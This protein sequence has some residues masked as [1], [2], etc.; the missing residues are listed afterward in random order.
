MQCLKKSL[1]VVK[2]LDFRLFTTA[3]YN[4]E[5]LQAKEK[6]HRVSSNRRLIYFLMDEKSR[7]KSAVEEILLQVRLDSL[8]AKIHNTHCR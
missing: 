1:V 3:S 4:S 2:F 6:K 8:C 7:S 5:V